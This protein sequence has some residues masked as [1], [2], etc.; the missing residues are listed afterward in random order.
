LQAFSGDKG[1]FGLAESF[2]QAF[3]GGQSGSVPSVGTPSMMKPLSAPTES[4]SAQIVNPQMAQ[5]QRDRL[6]QAMAR[7][8]S[9]QLFV[10]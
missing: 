3:G 4:Q 6:A 2:Q 5:M 7:L 8:N 10:G 9:G 1:D